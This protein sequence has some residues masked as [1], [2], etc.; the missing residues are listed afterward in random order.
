MLQRSLAAS[1]GRAALAVLLMLCI[2]MPTMLQGLKAAVLAVAVVCVLAAQLGGSLRLGRGDVLLLVAACAYSALGLAWAVYGEARGNPGAIPM[3]TVHAAYPPLLVFIGLLARTGDWQKVGKLLLFA[4]FVVLASQAAFIL[5]FFGLDNGVTFDFLS[6]LLPEGAAVVDA[7]DDYLIFT[8]PSIGSLLFL[9]PWLAV[10][11]LESTEHRG[12]AGVLFLLT[13]FAVL[14]AARRASL[15][16]FVLGIAVTLWMSRSLL[17]VRA[18]RR[19]LTAAAVTALLLGAAFQ[20]GAVNADLIADRFGSIFDFQS[21][22]SNIERRLQFTAL[23]DGIEQSPLIG[24]GLGAV[25]SYLRSDEQPWAY[26]LSYMA[27]LF[28]FGI[29][30]FAAYAAGMLQMLRHMARR[31]RSKALDRSQRVA[32]ACLIAGLVS[33]LIAN[34]TN[35][36]LAKFDYMW[37]IFLPLALLRRSPPKPAAARRS[38]RNGALL[39]APQGSS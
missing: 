2:V 24:S 7:N 27:L 12:K 25:A 20:S 35:P 1:V 34:A 13:V 30:G 17:S 4:A 26:E 5:S 33:F 11:F 39:A 6:G 10:L 32:F 21:N 31:V 28:Q 36:Y 19:L 3:L 8:L 37:V 18:W 14:L 9:G 38:T 15:P 29:L 22:D 23:V 16:A